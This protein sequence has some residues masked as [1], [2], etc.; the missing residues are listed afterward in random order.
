MTTVLAYLDPGSGSMI[1]QIIAGGLA[2]VAVTAKLYWNRILRFLHIRK[3]EPEAAEPAAARAP[4]R[5]SCGFRAGPHG[6]SRR[7]AYLRR[8]RGP[9]HDT[10]SPAGL[11]PGSFRDPE[12]RVFY[13]D[14]EVYRALSADGLS[15]FEALEATGLLDDERVVRT[16]RADED[17]RRSAAC[18]CTSPRGAEA[19]AHPVHLV[20]LRVDVLDAEGRGAAPARPA[21][22]R[23]GAGPRPEGLHALQRAVPGRAGRC[24]WTSGSFERLREGEPWVGYRQFCM[25]YLYPLLLQSVKGVPFH[26]WLRGSIDGITPAQMRSLLSFRDRFQ[27][28]LFTNVFLHAR[29]EARYADQPQRGQGRGQARGL[30]EGDRDGQRAQDAQARRA[31]RPGTRP[32]ASGP[33]T[34]SATATPTTTRSARTTSCARW[35]R[36]RDWDLVWDIGANNGRYSRIAA[37]GASHG[38]GRGRRPGPGRAALPRPARGGQREDPHAHDE[39]GR[40]VA[41]PRLARARAQGRCPTAGSRTSC[42]PSR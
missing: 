11:E 36:S 29:L 1:L 14:G 13:S 2:A 15:D 23:A 25:L 28:G 35:P 10:S 21:A 12:S 5:P 37:E 41:G 24:S 42:S 17:T 38:R 20:P 27:Q 31:A 30:Q 7:E 39:P 32:R 9:A 18:S 40:P 3:D 4:T 33:P 6:G 8:R 19:R 34:A 26:P 22:G 16:E